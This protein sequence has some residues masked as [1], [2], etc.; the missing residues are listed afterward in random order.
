MSTDKAL[1]TAK[2]SYA[3]HTSWHVRQYSV[4]RDEDLGYVGRPPAIETMDPATWMT[5]G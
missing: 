2:D 4:L 3:K 1:S 5:V